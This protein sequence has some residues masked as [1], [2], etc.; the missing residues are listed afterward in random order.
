MLII[1]IDFKSIFRK[2]SMQE[3]ILFTH[4]FHIKKIKIDN[5]LKFSSI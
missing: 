3:I 1:C 5:L 4:I 2:H